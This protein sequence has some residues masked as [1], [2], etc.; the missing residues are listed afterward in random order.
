[1]L[2]AI[3]SIE[4]IK[5]RIKTFKGNQLS[6]GFVPTMGALHEGHLSLVRQARKEND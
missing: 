2:Q 1:M 4:D 5:R 3:A 6:I